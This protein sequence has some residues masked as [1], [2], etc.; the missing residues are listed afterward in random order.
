MPAYQLMLAELN[1]LLTRDKI[2]DIDP[3]LFREGQLL[4]DTLPEHAREE[5]GF[6]LNALP[7]ALHEAIRAVLRNA[8]QR[9]MPVTLAWAPAYD[10]K[11]SVWDVSSTENTPGGITV[12]LECRYPDHPH[13]LH[14]TMKATAERRSRGA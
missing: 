4:A 1:Q 3:D 8:I 14:G 5:M 11:L 13:P 12:F 9:R 10:F 2:G 6:T 7:D